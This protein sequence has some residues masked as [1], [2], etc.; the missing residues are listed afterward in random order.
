[1]SVYIQ[2]DLQQCSGERFK[3]VS[4]SDGTETNHVGDLDRVSS[5]VFSDIDNGTQFAE[6][7]GTGCTL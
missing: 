2:F 5:A 4:I 6:M 7:K 1:M 3:D